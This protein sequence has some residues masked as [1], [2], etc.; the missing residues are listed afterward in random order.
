MELA[1]TRVWTTHINLTPMY[2]NK[3]EGCYRNDSVVLLR[4]CFLTTYN[5]TVRS[6]ALLPPGGDSLHHKYRRFELM[7][8]SY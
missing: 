2:F 7:S 6:F 1:A 3:A 8:Q 5:K 4:R